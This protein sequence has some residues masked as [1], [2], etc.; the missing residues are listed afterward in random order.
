MDDDGPD[1]EVDEDGFTSKEVEAFKK[2]LGKDPRTPLFEDLT[3]ADEAVVDGGKTIVLGARPISH[4]DMD[5]ATNGIAPGAKFGT[6]LELK[7]WIK[8]FSVKHFRPYTVVHSDMKKRYTVKCAEDR[9]PWIVRARPFKGGPSWHIVSCVQTHMC[10]GQKM[11]GKDVNPDHRQ[12]TSEFIAYRLSNSI[13]S[14]P[15][16]KIQHIIDMVKQIF[17]HQVKYGKAWKAKQIAFKMLYGDW[18]E[19]YNRLP[20]LLGAMA[21]TNPGM[22]HVV[23]PY[24]E[25]TMMHNGRIVRVFGRAFW[26]F[27]QC[28]RAF[29]HCRPVISVDG[30]FLTGQYKGTLLVAIASDAN[31]R[32]VPLAFALVEAENN[33]NWEWFFHLLRTKVLPIER[34]ICVISDRHQGILNAVEIEILGHPPLHHRWCMRHFCA[35]F[36]RACGKKELAEDL[37]NICL[38]FSERRFANLYNK[39]LVNNKLD[40]GGHDFLNRNILLRTKWARAY[41][42]DGRRYGQ[43]TNNMAE[44]FNSIFKG[45][46]ALPVTAI[47]EY[48]SPS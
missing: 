35:N 19:A 26:A 31:N 6:F 7:I 16:M 3:L 20:R 18:E 15:T 29:E 34:E 8:E 28:V 30:T 48:T 14:L 44:C 10:R 1:E 17:F 27:E 25:K 23:E 40:A 5:H 36:F 38:A 11:D 21:A 12:L 41:D 43:M 22:V 24:G 46:R 42:D 4:R 37:K 33:V 47:V 2:V 32:L 45:V 13:S 39:L 9:C